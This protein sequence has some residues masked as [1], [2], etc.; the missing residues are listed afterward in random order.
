MDLFKMDTFALLLHGCEVTGFS[1]DQEVYLYS[2]IFKLKAL[3]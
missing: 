3:F 2:K 1:S